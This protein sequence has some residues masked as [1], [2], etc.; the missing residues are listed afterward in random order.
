[1]TASYSPKRIWLAFRF[2]LTV[3]LIIRR[4][5]RF[6][7]FR[8]LGPQAL[9]RCILELGVSFIK[10]AQVLATRADFFSDAYLY[11]LRTIHDEVEPMPAEELRTMYVR[12]FGTE[13]GQGRPFLSFDEHPIASASIGQVHKA[14]LQDG[15]TAAVK[16]RRLGITRR[17]RCDIRI[18]RVFLGLFQPL[19]STLTKNSIDAVIAEFSSMIVKEVD[20]SIECENLKKFRMLYANQGVRFPEPYESYCSQD[21]LV[22]RFEQGV[23][24]DNLELLRENRTSLPD[25]IGKIV[26]FYTEQML[27]RGF[28]H[29]DPHPGN[30]LVSPSGQLILLDFG[31]VKRLQKSTRI[32]MIELVK[33]ANEQDFELFITSC[34]N[35]GIVAAGAP[36]DQ[37]QELAER[38]FDIFGNTNLNAASMQALAFEMLH[39]MKNL[40]FKVPQEIVYVMRASALIEGLGTTFDETFNG[41]KDILPILRQN[42]PRALG[43]QARIFPTLG[44][45]IKDLP[46][47]IRRAKTTLTDLSNGNLRVKVSPETLELLAGQLRSWLRPILQGGILL[48]AAFFL[49]QL[50]FSGHTEWSILCFLLGAARILL[51]LR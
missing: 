26:I 7:F 10:L 20:L 46:L 48:L 23:R 25:L 18:L 4:Q 3:F 9:K 44:G 12:A 51:S 38:M 43:A 30:L 22:M 15:R 8:P 39:S 14:V 21:A 42:L 16:I 13:P 19:F 27:I 1:M 45:E 31:M 35:L 33:A 36:E 6:L 11:E 2:L 24:I 5:E 50:H 28:F 29:A 34:K 17:V 41:V 40:P 49:L 47:T 37:M 32:A